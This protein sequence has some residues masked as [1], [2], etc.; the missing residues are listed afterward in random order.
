MD[1]DYYHF[2]K[3]VRGCHGSVNVVIDALTNSVYTVKN[4]ISTKYVSVDATVVVTKGGILKT[5]WYNNRHYRWAI[6]HGYRGECYIMTFCRRYNKHRRIIL[7]TKKE[8]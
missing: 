2:Y 1:V 5:F 7:A 4:E 8:V 3:R 6:H